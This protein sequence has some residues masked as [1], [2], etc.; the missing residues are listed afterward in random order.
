MLGG[1]AWL[2]R[3][4][5]EEALR[6]GHE[7]TCLARGSAD[8]PAGATFVTGDRDLDDGL[9]PVA[10]EPW[11]AVVD[12]TRHPGHARRA[13]RDLGAA[14]RVLV[15]TGN[16]YATFEALEQAEDA[17]LRGPLDGDLMTD[18]EVYGEAKVACESAVRE[19]DGTATIVR[20]GLIGGPGDWSGRTG[21]WPWRFA[22]PVGE[23]VVV[24]DELDFPCAIIDV[25]DL[26]AWLVTAAE[27]R[28]DGTFNATG[29]TTPLHEVLEVAA[30]VSGSTADLLP[31][32]RERLAELGVGAW[33][34]PASLP[35]WIDDAGW[36]G[37]ATMD[38]A[39][40]R[41]AG[42]VT[43][44][45]EET[46][47]DTLSFEETRTVPRRAGLDDAD[48]RRVQEAVLTR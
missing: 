14:H 24:P 10:G 36:R 13:V 26:A 1:T 25:R 3:T 8:P 34:G 2:G 6:R 18:M 42:L 44:P 43:R 40:A 48:E 30:R 31:V 28:L 27:D 22:H 46:L 29:P 20:S 15:S 32:G 17:P 12:V 21:Y 4:V 39:R 47:R 5:T 16:V 23:H 33:M 38:T 45:L 35:L 19:A 9:A 37:F 7:V 41:A 11:D